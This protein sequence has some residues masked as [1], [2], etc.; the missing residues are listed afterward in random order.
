[1]HIFIMIAK[2]SVEKKQIPLCIN[3]HSHY[4]AP[5]TQYIYIPFAMQKINRLPRKMCTLFASI[6]AGNC[7]VTTKTQIMKTNRRKFVIK[8]VKTKQTLANCYLVSC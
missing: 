6:F 2:K 4:E 3:D 5:Y 8:K 1:M 7:F